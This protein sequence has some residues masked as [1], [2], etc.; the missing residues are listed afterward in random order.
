MLNLKKTA[1]AVLALSSGAVFAGTM[2]PVCSAVN[3]T[4]PCETTAW[5]VGAR[6]LYLQSSVT[7]G[8]AQME[9][10]I[11]APN[12]SVNFGQDPKWGWGFMI[13]GSYLF[14]TGNDVNVNWYHINNG[15]SR[16]STGARTISNDIF[17]THFPAITAGT[18]TTVSSA[19]ASVSP[20]WDAVNIEFGQHVDFGENT[21][22]RFHGGF[23]YAR[24]AAKTTLQLSGTRVT[25]TGGA[26]SAFNAYTSNNPSY[27][28]FGPRLGADMGYDWGNGL[29]VYAN[30]AAGL[31]AGSS[32][33]STVYTDNATNNSVT[34][35][36]SVMTVV[37]ELEGKLGANYTYA[38]AQ[39]D[40][41]LDVGWMWINY[42][43]V[44]R[45]QSSTLATSTQS[46]DVGF[47][48]LYFGLKWLGN[49]A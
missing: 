35:S 14:G 45:S 44:A 2:G 7:G 3:V 27:N 33:F 16:S 40:L 5:G 32:K 23:E 24:L 13:E 18:S 47:Q 30:G 10:T 36:G 31:L 48:G 42:F 12:Q 41:T 43:N 49:V 19:S 17:A 20:Q 46:G 6:A 26:A 34:T 9:K 39:G 25:T 11:T 22:I 4:V 38:M 8:T 15:H 29:G 21:N 28:G 37:P 1:V